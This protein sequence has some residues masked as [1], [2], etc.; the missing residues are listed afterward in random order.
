MKRE[1]E[2]PK[3]VVYRRVEGMEGREGNEENPRLAKIPSPLTLAILVMMV[4]SGAEERVDIPK[5]GA[6]SRRK[7]SQLERR[8]ATRKGKGEGKGERERS[9]EKDERSPSCSSLILRLMFSMISLTDVRSRLSLE[10]KK[11]EQK[12]RSVSLDS[13]SDIERRKEEKG[14]KR[15]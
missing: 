14:K 6:S 3:G 11:E 7:E 12:T 15:T 4:R 9:R 10:R 5:G 13:K 2:M 1:K 8:G